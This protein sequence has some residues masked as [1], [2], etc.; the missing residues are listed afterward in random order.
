[1]LRHDIARFENEVKSEDQLWNFFK[2]TEPKPDVIC[3]T[4]SISKSVTPKGHGLPCW[5]R[6]APII[7]TLLHS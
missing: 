3:F 2:G 4:G 5:Q 6:M 7:A 1:M